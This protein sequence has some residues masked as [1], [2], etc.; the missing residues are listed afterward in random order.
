MDQNPLMQIEPSAFRGTHLSM[1]ILNQV[2]LTHGIHSIPTM[3]LSRLRGL[4]LANNDM[5]TLTREWFTDLSSLR[6]LNLDDNI[7]TRIPGDV[8][9][10]VARTLTTLELNSNR[11]TRVPRQSIRKLSQLQSLHLRDNQISK[12]HARSFNESRMLVTLDLSHN[13]ISDVSSRAFLG[14]KSVAKLDLRHNA[15]LTLDEKT[16]SY[17]NASNTRRI[18]LSSN[19]WLC[20]CLLK[21]L[22]RDYKKQTE[23]VRSIVDMRAVRCTRPDFLLGKP[24]IRISTKTLTCDHDYYYYYDD[25]DYPI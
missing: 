8:F 5:S 14:L 7:L 18:Y 17:L 21:W 2:N 16:F 24:L 19:P 4:S 13:Q 23:M 22:R 9:S 20:N 11:F 12:V 1:L 10:G 6:Y 3:D 15:L 25:D